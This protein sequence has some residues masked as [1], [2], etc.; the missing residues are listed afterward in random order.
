MEGTISSDIGS[1][2]VLRCFRFSFPL[3]FEG[4][5]RS[6]SD[7]TASF[8]PYRACANCLRRGDYLYHFVFAFEERTR[9]THLGELKRFGEQGFSTV[10]R[11]CLVY[12]GTTV[13][14]FPS[15]KH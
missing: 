5:D 1:T 9:S 15:I 7:D 12:Q 4:V 13:N 3:Y 10:I 6:G 2:P 11:Y 14:A 8:T